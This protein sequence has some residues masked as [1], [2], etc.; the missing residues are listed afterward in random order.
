MNDFGVLESK[1]GGLDFRARPMKGAALSFILFRP[2]LEPTA[3]IS[4]SIADMVAAMGRGLSQELAKGHGN[5]G[6]SQI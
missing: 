6:L 2:S 1:T 3:A 5:Y 4:R